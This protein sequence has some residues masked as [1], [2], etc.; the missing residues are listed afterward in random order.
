M[1]AT[2][3][4]IPPPKTDA[5]VSEALRVFMDPDASIKAR[6]NATAC[7][8]RSDNETHR[9]IARDMQETIALDKLKHPRFTV[10]VFVIAAVIHILAIIGALT[11]GFFITKALANLAHMQVWGM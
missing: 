10:A 2:I 5:R 4:P 8:S 9:Y 7:L 1:T 11:V 3:I 6:R